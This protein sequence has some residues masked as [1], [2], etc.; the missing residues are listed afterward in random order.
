MT[1]D[2]TS[3]YK[4]PIWTIILFVLMLIWTIRYYLK[5][6]KQY[7]FFDRGFEI[8]T[9]FR[10]EFHSWKTIKEISIVKNSYEKILWQYMK[11]DVLSIYLKNEKVFELYSKYYKNMPQ[12]RQHLSSKNNLNIFNSYIEKNNTPLSLFNKETYKGSFM[13]CLEGLLILFFVI[14]F[15]LTLIAKWHSI[16]LIGLFF[17]I[18]LPLFVVLVIGIKAY[19]FQLNQ[20][21]LIVKNHIF[22]HVKHKIDLEKVK[23]IYFEQKFKKE[24]SIKIIKDDYSMIS[25]QSV[26]LKSKRW[27]SLIQNLK[28]RDISIVDE[29]F[30]EFNE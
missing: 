6:F 23:V 5:T 17:M 18:G 9:V 20:K 1:K 25:F 2:G 27:K 28:K 15:G 3:L 7:T 29:L 16:T 22:I 8:K 11:E 12:I 19:Y 13:F 21:Y 26:S 30:Y 4:T 24:P 10:K 14:S